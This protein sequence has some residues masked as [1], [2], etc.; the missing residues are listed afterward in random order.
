MQDAGPWLATLRR[1]ALFIAPANLLWE[2]LHVPL[3][4]IWNEGTLGE[5]AFAVVHCT[6]G[7]LVIALG[8][9]VTALIVCG[10]SRWPAE[11][12]GAVTASAVILGLA[13][14]AYSEWLNVVVRG[15]WF[16]SDLMPAVPPLGTGLSPLLQWL[17]LPPLGLTWARRS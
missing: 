1:Y 7:D 4:S 15:S 13:Y 14:A 11:R 6:G 10:G 3:Y 17:T 16:Y 2:A 5:I 9:L 8:C 12:F